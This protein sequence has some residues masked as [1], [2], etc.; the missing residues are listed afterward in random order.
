MIE[1]SEMLITALRRE[2]PRILNILTAK[3]GT[4]AGTP[5]VSDER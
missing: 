3:N 4:G 1:G 5:E 2:H